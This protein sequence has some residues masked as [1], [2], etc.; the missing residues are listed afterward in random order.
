MTHQRDSFFPLWNKKKKVSFIFRRW[1]SSNYI[2]KE[3]PKTQGLK[4]PRIGNSGQIINPATWEWNRPARLGRAAAG[5]G[6]GRAPVRDG[7][8][9]PAGGQGR[10]LGRGCCVFPTSSSHPNPTSE[11]GNPTSPPRRNSDRE[12]PPRQWHRRHSTP[13][14]KSRA[15]QV[16]RDAGQC[17]T[18]TDGSSTARKIK[19]GKLDFS[20]KAIAALILKNK[21]TRRFFSLHVTDRYTRSP[22]PE[23]SCSGHR[24][25][26]VQSSQHH[27]LETCRIPLV[28]TCCIRQSPGDHISENVFLSSLARPRWPVRDDPPAMTSPGPRGAAELDHSSYLCFSIFVTSWIEHFSYSNGELNVDK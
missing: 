12:G 1:K 8:P 15:T 7:A 26:P 19:G 10:G 11:R 16:E 27:L 24:Q 6:E 3:W 18:V 5:G 2:S 13:R 9:G 23:E 28:H 17:P 14:T 22:Q 25:V 4:G 21:D 20:P